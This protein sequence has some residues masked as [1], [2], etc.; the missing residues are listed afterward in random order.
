MSLFAPM[1]CSAGNSYGRSKA[2][3][4]I[5]GQRAGQ[6][7]KDKKPCYGTKILICLVFGRL[8]WLLDT[9]QAQNNEGCAK[10]KL[11]AV[12]SHLTHVLTLLGYES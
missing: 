11:Q 6:R 5:T 8:V 4:A 12:Y 1:G 2:E 9:K 3:Q 7:D 10:L